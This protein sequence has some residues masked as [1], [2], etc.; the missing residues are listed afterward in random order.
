MIKTVSPLIL[1]IINIYTKQLANEVW[2]QNFL[3]S[4]CLFLAHQILDI[5]LQ[6]NKMVI[7]LPIYLFEPR[8]KNASHQNHKQPGTQLLNISFC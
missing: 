7:A 8:T 5:L 1:Y 3:I 4:F 6:I 2:C